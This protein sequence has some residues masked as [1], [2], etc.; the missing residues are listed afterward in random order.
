M[1]A[2]DMPF[3]HL[4]GP[5]S[6]YRRYGEMSHLVPCNPSSVALYSYS[7]AHTS[8]ITFGS[9]TFVAIRLLMSLCSKNGDRFSFQESAFSIHPYRI[10]NSLHVSGHFSSVLEARGAPAPSDVA[11]G[12][13]K[14]EYEQTK[15]ALYNG[16]PVDRR[17]RRSWFM[18]RLLP[19][20]R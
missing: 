20:S 8:T 19:D 16:R 11:T 18:M 6:Q 5:I 2:L 7:Q 9:M 13:E 15:R 3:F 10:S 17:A 14:Y 4:W 12:T 1:S